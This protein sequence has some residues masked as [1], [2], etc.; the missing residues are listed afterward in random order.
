MSDDNAPLWKAQLCFVR[1]KCT[2]EF[3]VTAN[4]HGCT[5][6]CNGISEKGPAV[7]IACGALHVRVRKTVH[8]PIMEHLG[9]LS[10]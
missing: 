5:A 6:M 4:N 9:S 2:R 3:Q 1:W 8:E 7:S 10:K